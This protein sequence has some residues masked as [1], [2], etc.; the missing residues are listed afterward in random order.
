MA[1]DYGSMVTRIVDEL[2]LPVGDTSLVPQIK[3]EI[4]SA[5]LLYERELFW[6]DEGQA[7]INTAAAT[8]TVT[9]PADLIEIDSIDLTYGG[10]PYPLKRKGWNW[11]VDVGARDTTVGKAPPG[12]YVFYQNL[13]YLYP[14]PDAIYALQ[15]SY[16]KKLAVLSADA[17][18]NSWMTEGEELIR[19]RAR[20]AVRVN[21]RNDSV[22][23]AELLQMASSGKK[24]YGWQ[25]EIAYK[26]LLRTNT[27]KIST[28]RIVSTRF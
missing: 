21:Y 5:I 11:Y 22:A 19:N 1:G 26:S 9:P 17:D 23:K 25:E 4:Q 12:N 8:A 10:H 2:T 16:K 13:L 3:L 28:G 20:Q 14:V 6:F 27:G 18:T 7:A 24:Y 15:L